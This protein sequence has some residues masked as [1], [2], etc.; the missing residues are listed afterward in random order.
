MIDRK[1]LKMCETLLELGLGDDDDTFVRALI[2]FE[3]E[4]LDSEVSQLIRLYE[5]EIGYGLEG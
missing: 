4:L 5:K 1:H 2:V 3:Q